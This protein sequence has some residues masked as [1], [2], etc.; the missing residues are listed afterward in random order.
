MVISMRQLY[1]GLF[2]ITVVV[3]IDRSVIFFLEN[4]V[5][6]FILYLIAL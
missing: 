1:L 2:F 5:S 6:F 4:S 3:C